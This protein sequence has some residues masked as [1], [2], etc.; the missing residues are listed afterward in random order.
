[1]AKIL[2]LYPN[3]QGHGITAIWIPSHS[4]VLKSKGHSVE[5]FDGTFFKNWTVDETAFNTKNKMYKPSDYSTYVSFTSDDIYE[6]LQNHINKFQPDG[7]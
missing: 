2:F 1:M 3:K 7:W 4:A 6:S 5:L